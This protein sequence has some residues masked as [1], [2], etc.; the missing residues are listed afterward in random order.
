MACCCHGLG[1][2]AWQMMLHTVRTTLRTAACKMG[3]FLS[4]QHLVALAR[5]L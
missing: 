3:S 4:Y 2:N 1:K 5:P